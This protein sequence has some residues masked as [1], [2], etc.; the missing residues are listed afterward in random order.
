MHDHIAWM[1]LF[2]T[3]RIP[4]PLNPGDQIALVAPARFVSSEE[5]LNARQMIEK[6]GF[7]AHISP[8]LEARFGQF[9][10]TDMQRANLLNEAFKMSEIRAVWAMR[11]GYGCARI[12]PLLDAEAFQSD[13]KWIVGFSDITALHAWADLQGVGSL[14]GP[15]ANTYH[16]TIPEHASLLWA[17]LSERT[18]SD[19]VPVVGGNLSVLYSLLGTSYFPDL[20]GCWL[21]IEDLDEYLYHIDRML[22]A[23]KLSGVLEGIH[24]VLVGS[25]CE[26]RDNTKAFGQSKDNPFGRS[27]NEMIREHVPSGKPIHWDFPI[28][29]GSQNK[30]LVLGG[31]L[32]VS[33]FCE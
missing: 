6:A 10:G 23:F 32:D 25:F 1:H 13:P 29:H 11:G 20:K 33:G 2:R 28:G 30:P 12:L 5:I 27:V 19:G 4:V 7:V 21:L 15:V 26:L 31:G 9:G 24:G 3:R 16:S 18:V 22:L 8:N 14:H 17:K